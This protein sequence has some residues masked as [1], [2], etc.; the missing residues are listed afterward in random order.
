ML[1]QNTVR[2]YV[3][4]VDE[5]ADVWRPVD[6]DHLGGDE[7]QILSER[8]NKNETWQFDTD[9]VVRCR[10]RLLDGESCLVAYA[11]AD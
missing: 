8:T 3:K 10:T 2:I 11:M 4:L 5:G 7:Y 1:E 9:D 6:A